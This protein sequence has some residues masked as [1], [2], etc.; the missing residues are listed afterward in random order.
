MKK[1]GKHF[2]AIFGAVAAIALAASLAQAG[3]ARMLTDEELDQI[4]AANVNIDFQIPEKLDEMIARASEQTPGQLNPG[5]VS[6]FGTVSVGN[7]S[8]SLI[9][10]QTNMVIL[11]GSASSGSI[12]QSN[13]ANFGGSQK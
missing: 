13:I 3:E 7:A 8:N 9:V 10:T 6:G 11:S 2:I 4:T 5:A 1:F 12:R